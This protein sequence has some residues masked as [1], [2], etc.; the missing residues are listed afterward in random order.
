MN[1]IGILVSILNSYRLFWIG[2][3][4]QI[5]PNISVIICIIFNS[6]NIDV[7]VLGQGTLIGHLVFTLILIYSVFSLAKNNKIKLLNNLNRNIFNDLIILSKKAIPLILVILIAQWGVIELNSSLS[8]LNE[9]TLSNFGFAWKLLAIVSILPAAIGAVLLPSF[10][11]SYSENDLLGLK[12]LTKNAF[13]MSVY[14]TIPVTIFLCIERLEII[15]LI[16]GWKK[17]NGVAINETAI[18]FGLLILGVPASACSVTLSKV[19]IVMNDKLTLIIIAILL[20]SITIFFA[21]LTCNTWGVVGLSVMCSV[22]SWIGLTL[23]LAIQSLRYN[24]I[25]LKESF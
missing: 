5:L 14:I 24:I 2:S 16:F 3:L 9:G 15:N 21:D 20:S 17:M 6:E 23:Q 22:I 10:S 8:E 19:A 12:N 13:S 1:I 25:Q 11:Y 7:E 4:A 18:I